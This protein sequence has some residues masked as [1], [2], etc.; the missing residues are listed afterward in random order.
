[1]INEP[2]LTLDDKC[3]LEDMINKYGPKRVLS[4]AADICLVH[5]NRVAE[6][7]DEQDTSDGWR[8]REIA[9]ALENAATEAIGL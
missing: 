3:R 6:S 5:A 1:M 8:W 7:G 2:E 9:Y 4:C